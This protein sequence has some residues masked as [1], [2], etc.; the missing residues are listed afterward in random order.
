M[1]NADRT[2]S[3]AAPSYRERLSPSLWVLVSA[4]V[5]APMAA[6]VFAPLDGTIALAVGF[7]VGAAIVVA[8]LATAPTIAV[9][10]GVLRVGR[11]RIPVSDLGTPEPLE[12]QAARSARGPELGRDDWHLLRGG[13]DGVVRVPVTDV[14]DPATHWV[15][16]SRTPDRVAAMITRAQRGR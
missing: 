7:A 12:G 5:C 4:A 9:V 11:A 3:T 10:D 6:I 13:V 2:T 14:E 8:L 16:S 1:H 15:F